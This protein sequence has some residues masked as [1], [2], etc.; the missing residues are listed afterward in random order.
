MKL[1]WHSTLPIAPTISNCYLEYLL[2]PLRRWL[3]RERKEQKR[4][5][6]IWIKRHDWK[7]EQYSVKQSTEVSLI[8]ARN[9]Y[10]EI[11]ELLV[12]PQGERF[13]IHKQL[14]CNKSPYFEA[15]F[16]GK[17]KEAKKKQMKLPEDDVTA[18]KQFQHWLYAGTP[19][20]N[21]DITECTSINHEWKVLVQLY[22]LGDKYQIPT[23]QNAATHGIIES[24][25]TRRQTSVA[26]YI[27]AYEQTTPKSQLRKLLVDIFVHTSHDEG[28]DTGFNP[29]RLA[30]YP[31][32]F[33]FDVAEAHSRLYRG[34]DGKIYDFRTVRSRYHIEV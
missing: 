16:K 5:R 9:L 30:T 1:H 34:K 22:I 33:L 24:Q 29:D 11:V 21:A 25:H 4:L 17:F 23:L 32:E 28:K 31:Q 15:A 12:G 6:V 3:R 2:A 27:L 13:T 19:L 8:K 10:D 14:L 7:G 26:S 20:P 18:F